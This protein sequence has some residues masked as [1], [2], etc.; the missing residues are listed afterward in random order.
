MK[1]GVEAVVELHDDLAA[2]IFELHPNTEVTEDLE[3]IEENI[4]NLEHIYNY[5]LQLL[6]KTTH[7][8]RQMEMISIKLRFHLIPREN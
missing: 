5:T 2:H 7:A 4:E 6:D 1:T 8:I 3:D